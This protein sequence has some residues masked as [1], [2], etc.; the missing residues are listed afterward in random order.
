M[1]ER[2]QSKRATLILPLFVALFC[3]LASNAFGQHFDRTDLT[4]NQSGIAPN[5]DP[6]LVNAWGLSRSSGSPWWV[7]DNG[8]GLST[9]YNGA[10]VPQ[11]LVVT[12]PPPKGQKGPSTPTGN[13]FNFTSDFN[14]E[15]GLKAIFIFV[16]EDGTISGWN[17]TLDLLHARRRIDHSGRAIYKGIA[18]AT[19][20]QGSRIYVTNFMTGQVEVYNGKWQRVATSPTAF[21]DPTLPENYVPFGIQNVGGNIVVTFAHREPGEEDEDHGP[22]LGFVTI[23]NTNGEVIARLKHGDYFNA[24]WGIAMSG[25][26]FGAFSHRLLIGNFGDGQIHAFDPLTGN[27]AGTLLDAAGSPIWIDGLW[28]L[29]FG[30]GNGNSGAANEL[31]FTAGPDDE[32]NGLFGKLAAVPAEQRGSSE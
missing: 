5:M 12:I 7:S 14:L 30:G 19:A 26:D 22:G 24:P 20:R 23:F 15:P 8:T 6:N 1:F 9:L 10:G 32:S 3:M 28:A 2:P 4:S 29:E 25:A 11:S 21:V 17:P 13:V 16:T 27:L 18:L 31:F